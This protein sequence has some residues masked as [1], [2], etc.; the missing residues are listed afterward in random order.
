MFEEIVGSSDALA[1]CWRKSRKVA[2]T[3]LDGL[4]HGETGTG[5]ELIARAIHN[6]S[7]RGS[8]AFIRVNCCAILPSLLASELSGTK[9]ARSRSTPETPRSFAVSRRRH[10]LSG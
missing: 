4:I 2:P 5:K 9:R 7:R 10:D 6:R 8:R 1:A 3:R